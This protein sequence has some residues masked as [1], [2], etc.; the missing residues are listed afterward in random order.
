MASQSACTPEHAPD[1][2]NDAE[3]FPSTFASHA[4]SSDGSPF[5]ATFDWQT[6]S[7]YS[8]LAI[9]FRRRP[10]HLSARAVPAER[11]S[12]ATRMVPAA[13]MRDC[14]FDMVRVLPL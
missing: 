2:A 7:P 9:A 13:A 11:T 4:A 1:L 5:C 3:N 14:S 10:V 8:F 6:R 12:A